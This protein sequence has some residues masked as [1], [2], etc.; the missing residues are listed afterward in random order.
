MGGVGW[1]VSGTQLAAS[2]EWVKGKEGKA[3]AVAKEAFCG[4]PGSSGGQAGDRRGVEIK[5]GRKRRNE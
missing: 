5:V 2:P 1:L 3:G 4:T